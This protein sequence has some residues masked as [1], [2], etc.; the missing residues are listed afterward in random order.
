M[1]RVTLSAGPDRGA[2]APFRRSECRSAASSRIRTLASTGVLSLA[3]AVA[4]CSRT[5]V[6]ET[7]E[8]PIQRQDSSNRLRGALPSLPEAP[9]P[10]LRASD[11]GD[12]APGQIETV[13][14]DIAIESGVRREL[15]SVQGVAQH[16][17]DVASQQGIVTLAGTVGSAG[18][19]ASVLERVL[20]VNGVR[21][22]VSA[23]EVDPKVV[24]DAEIAGQVESR[25]KYH[26]LIAHQSL[27]ATVKDGVVELQGSLRS[28]AEREVAKQAAESVPG[29]RAVDNRI[30][31]TQV[32][33]SSDQALAAEVS[34]RLAGDARLLGA[35]IAV[36][37]THG[38]VFLSGQVMSDFERRL[39]RE[40]SWTP[41]AHAVYDDAL[42][43]I[44]TRDHLR[45]ADALAPDDAAVTRA[46]ADALRVDS[47]VLPGSVQVRTENG[48]V[49][50]DGTVLS[51]DAREAAEQNALYTFGARAVRNRIRV[52]PA[53]SFST[54]ELPDP[55][56]QRNVGDRLKAHPGITSRRMRVSVDDGRVFLSG[57]ADSSYESDRAE[58]VSQHV[59]GVVGVVNRLQIQEEEKAAREDRDILREIELNFLR[60]PRIDPELV[61]VQVRRGVVT[62][63]GRVPDF[64]TLDAVLENV[65]KV[66]PLGLENELEVTR[67]PVPARKPPSAPK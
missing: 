41:S 52:A 28:L 5:P 18:A 31:L 47:R 57:N 53:R 44:E 58:G 61:Q 12:G 54:T 48:L 46:L 9:A 23:L 10:G 14:S 59:R 3:L 43:V 62:L 15:E 49:T 39:S 51:A 38:V 42:S 33:E 16:R 30:T 4:S 36:R 2:V 26:P 35:Q 63:R 7:P 29:V 67:R 37:V 11:V 45:D 66:L 1:A 21:A 34:R 25:L 60:D 8:R 32:E 65:F 56:I 20:E 13:V 17:I 55:V 50:L 6:S 64:A 24:S 22:A 40:L 27:R 19:R